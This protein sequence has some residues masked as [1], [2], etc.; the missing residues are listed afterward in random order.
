MDVVGPVETGDRAAS[1]E[2]YSKY[3]GRTLRRSAGRR[4]LMGCGDP[5]LPQR[6]WTSQP[7]SPSVSEG[8]AQVRPAE[9]RSCPQLWIT[10]GAH[11][12]HMGEPWPAGQMLLTERPEPL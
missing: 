9:K 10:C 8:C 2:H 4:L 3:D 6:L 1:N 11:R 7:V 12:D 5:G